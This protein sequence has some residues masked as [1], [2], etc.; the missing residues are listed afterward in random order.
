MIRSKKILVGFIGAIVMSLLAIFAFAGATSTASADTCD[1]ESDIAVM[2]LNEDES[3]YGLYT[4]LSISLNGGNGK[5]WA[6]VR[7]DLTILPSNVNVIVQ[8]YY[9]DTYCEDYKEMTLIAYN[10]TTD[11]DMGQSIVAEASTEGQERFWIGRMRFRIDSKGWQEDTI[12]PA[13]CSA[14][15]DYLGLT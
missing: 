15:G 2:S 5:V 8:L 7:N 12:G 6:T 11:L 1:N 10:S 3:V 14:N 9:S 13:R 4:S